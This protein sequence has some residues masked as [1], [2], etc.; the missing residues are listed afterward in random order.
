MKYIVVLIIL[1]LF[2]VYLNKRKVR[3]N[4]TFPKLYVSNPFGDGKHVYNSGYGNPWYDEPAASGIQGDLLSNLTTDKKY[5]T[6]PKTLN[7][8]INRKYN[9]GLIMNNKKLQTINDD[10]DKVINVDSINN[11]YKNLLTGKNLSK[12]EMRLFL[13]K[14][15]F[16]TWKERW[17]EYN[18]N[19]VSDNFFSLDKTYIESDIK[20]INTINKYFIKKFNNILNNVLT[21]PQLVIFGKSDLYIFNYKISNVEI[22]DDGTVIYT[23]YIILY[24]DGTDYSPLL[25]FKSFIKNNKVYIYQCSLVGYYITGNLLMPPGYNKNLT[26]NGYILNKYYNNKGNSDVL[27]HDLD[28]TIY[29]RKK[30]LDSYKL[31]NQYACFTTNF[32]TYLNPQ[33]DASVILNANNRDLCES[34]FD[35]YGK[36]KQSGLWDSPCKKDSDCLFYKVNKNYPN[37]YGKCGKDGYCKLPINMINMGYHFYLPTNK[38]KPCCYNCDTKEWNPITE[39]G[40]C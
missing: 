6:F 2:F 25:Y 3:E 29:M 10:I 35:Y 31:H 21:D 27:S 34:N 15:N 39:L 8:L 38:T 23:I 24:I 37:N 18:P 40:Y 12:D 28:R 17:R 32:N 33:K 7:T 26:D 19:K 1:F 20:D 30:Y 9:V 11:L 22:T 5:I 16:K 36:R 13:R 4:F 14:Q